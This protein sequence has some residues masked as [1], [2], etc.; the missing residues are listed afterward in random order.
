MKKKT[1]RHP[2]ARKMKKFRSQ[3]FAHWLINTYM[4]CRVADVGGG[5]GLISYLL[6]K[7]G[8][9]STVIDPEFQ[10]LPTKYR[11]LDKK[12]VKI[13]PA[14]AVPHVTAPFTKELANDFDL[15][16]GMHAHGCNMWI[17][18]ACEEY[19]KDFILLPCCVIDEP[20]VKERD[21]NWRESL[22]EYAQKKGFDVKKVQF[23]FKGKNI[24]IYSDRFLKRRADYDYDGVI[25][26]FMI[27][28]IRDEFCEE[29]SGH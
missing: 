14:E 23:N 18:D 21:I 27:D 11:A 12:R 6:N 8:W 2:K 22:V 4:P 24:A 28:P 5:K 16:I 1:V 20:I 9:Q 26:E 17:V 25:K 19:G 13:D 15:I 7:A 10:V 29:E 3:I